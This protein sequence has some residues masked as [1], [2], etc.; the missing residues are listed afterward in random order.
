M[1]DPPAR[2]QRTGHLPWIRCE[3]DVC[4]LWIAKNDGYSGIVATTGWLQNL[5]RK[6]CIP[7]GKTVLVENGRSKLPSLLIRFG[8]RRGA[9]VRRIF[10]ILLH[11]QGVISRYVQ[12]A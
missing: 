9:A 8:C 3:S 6:S 7:D 12:A 11:C 10:D 1:H 2:Q 4:R 5:A